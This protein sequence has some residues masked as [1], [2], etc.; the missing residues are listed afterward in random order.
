MLF[1]HGAK[2]PIIVTQG[3]VAVMS[4]GVLDG[5]QQNQ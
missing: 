3:F 4:K 1:H 5:Q 2:Q